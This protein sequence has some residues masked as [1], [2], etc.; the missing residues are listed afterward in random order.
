MA[1]ARGEA[2]L[3][4]L[5]R[6]LRNQKLEGSE[7]RQPA[8]V[9]AW[10]GAVQAQ[11]YPAAKWALGLRAEGLTDAAVDRAFDEGS[12]LRTHVLRP[13]WHFVTPADIRWM[14]ALTGARVQR[15]LE[16]YHRFVDLNRR[17]LTRCE[18]V[19]VR[20]L[21]GGRHLTRTELSAALRA[22]G[23]EATG[24]RLH[25]ILSD[26]ELRAVICSGPR[27][28][29]Q[30]TYALVDERVPR[31]LARTLS[32]DEALAELTRRFF[33]SHGPATVK[34]F[35]WWSGLTVAD[36]ERGLDMLGRDIEQTTIDGCVH[37]C[38][39]SSSASSAPPRTASSRS[40]LLL[41]NFD[42]FIVA[43]RDRT[44]IVGSAPP[45][46]PTRKRSL[47]RGEPTNHVFS[48]TLII[49]GRLAGVWRRT[50]KADAVRVDLWL[51][52][53]LTRPETRA[54]AAAVDRYRAFTNTNVI[55]SS[56]SQSGTSH[57]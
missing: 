29:K 5:A 56:T 40:A 11:D 25:H 13:T 8:D 1:K 34:D 53:R 54:F 10:L 19:L 46:D 9:V 3:P 57:S 48:H 49:D 7:L 55:I 14:Q 30:F 27:R 44:A 32:G 41:P 36:A 16:R 52:R 18:K 37:W 2:S 28:G 15:V 42:E 47:T 31:A 35:V 39:T 43:Y 21:Q 6:R 17:L 38:T 33:A 50:V 24:V 23:I 51:H 4:L 45:P 26:A 22:A 12:I 20:A